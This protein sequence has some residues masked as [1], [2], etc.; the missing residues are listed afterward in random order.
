MTKSNLFQLRIISSILV[1]INILVLQSFTLTAGDE[2]TLKVVSPSGHHETPEG[3]YIPVSRDEMEKSPAY[4]EDGSG[5]FTTQVNISDE[6]EN[7]LG[8]AANEPSMA[9]DPTNPDKMVIGWRQ[10]DTIISSFRQA[11]YGYTLDG[12]DT[13]TFP[14]VIDEGVF[15]SDPVLDSDADGNIFYNSLTAAGNNFWCD[16]Y[17]M[18]P[19]DTEWDEGTYAQGGDKQWMTIDKTD[20]IGRGNIYASWTSYYSICYPGFFTRSVDG[21]DSY[22]DCVQVSGSPYWGTLATGADGTLYAAGNSNYGF[23]VVRST[24]AQNDG[25]PVT[26]DAFSEVYLDGYISS[27]TGPNPGGLLGQTWVSVDNSDGPYS[28][29]VYLLCSVDRYS[30]DDPLDV[31]FSKSTDGGITWSE[32]KRVNQDNS[33]TNWQ[34]FGTMSVAPDGRIDVVW[35]DTRNNGAPWTYNSALFYAYSI[36]GG[37]TFSENEQVSDYFNPHLGWPQQNKM[38]DY[39]HMISD[40]DYAHLA[41]ANTLNGEQ[42]VYY[43]RINPW[44]VGMNEYEKNEQ[45]LLNVFPNPAKENTTIRYKLEKRSDV[46]LEIFDL[47][48]KKVYQNSIQGNEAG[49]HAEQISIV[50]FPDGV[51]YVRVNAEGKIATKKIVVSN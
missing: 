38:G 15:R 11:G 18:E 13:W 29:N 49:S 22:E 42:D 17:K 9:I 4:R 24:T 27:R 2:D 51:Y 5:F 1:L 34:W 6:G 26:W 44:F 28:G 35:L 36:D 45:L 46:A 7:M 43:T 50:N 12:G 37:E 8:D 25:G 48:G 21:G 40:Y 47:F 32:A 3:E 33:N 20:G 41:W 31:M 30:N 39:F 14:G 10:F 19:G 23:I 16:V